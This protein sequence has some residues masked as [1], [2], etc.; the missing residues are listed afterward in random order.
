MVGFLRRSILEN[1]FACFLSL[2]IVLPSL[3]L[4]G[5]PSSLRYSVA[6]RVCSGKSIFTVKMR[7]LTCVDTILLLTVTTAGIGVGA[8]AA[9]A[10]QRNVTAGRLIC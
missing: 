8:T 6:E 5:N 7:K 9:I 2:F 3:P 10:A 4:K 1:K